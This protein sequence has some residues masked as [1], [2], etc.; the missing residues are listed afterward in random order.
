MATKTAARFDWSDP[1][2]LEQQLTQDERMVRD[3][4]RA[5]CRDKLAP[6]V[7]EMFRKEST[8]TAIFREF[9]ALDM[10][11]IVIPEEYGGAVSPFQLFSRMNPRI[12]SPSSFAQ[13]MKTSAIGLLVIQ[14][15][16]PVI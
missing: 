11:G 8:D 10:L 1:L 3:T 7:L 16:V 15:L 4:A 12:S 5:Y 6:R 2:L 14:A 9:G 13:T